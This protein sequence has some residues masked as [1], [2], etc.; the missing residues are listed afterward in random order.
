MQSMKMKPGEE[1]GQMNGLRL[2]TGWRRIIAHRRLA[3]DRK[4][5]FEWQSR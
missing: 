2:I 1:L 3:Q 5:Q 4:C